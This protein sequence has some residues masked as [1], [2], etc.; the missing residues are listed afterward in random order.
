MILFA[1]LIYGLSP[2]NFPNETYIR[3]GT[4]DW[5]LDNDQTVYGRSTW[6][7]F[8]DYE[9][10]ETIRRGDTLK[11]YDCIYWGAIL[12]DTD[13]MSWENET[14]SYSSTSLTLNDLMSR[15]Q[16]AVSVFKFNYG[17]EYC[18][19]SFSIPKLENGANKYGDLN[20]AWESGE[21]YQII[22]KW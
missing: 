1:F 14:G 15:W 8:A 6:S 10:D 7:L 5:N 18:R 3:I 21:L 9:G 19:V 2:P 12:Y 13:A 20:E 16:D 11:L 17:D 22:E 4:N